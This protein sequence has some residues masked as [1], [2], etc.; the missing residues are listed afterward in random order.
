VAAGTS[1]GGVTAKRWGRV[2]D[3]PLIGAGTYASNKACAVSCTGAGEYFIRLSVAR[4]ICALVEL[5]G[6]SLQAACDQVVQQDLT[7][8]GGE[9]GV[10]AVGPGGETAW[11]FNT[12]GMY[13]ARIAE[14]E[15]MVVGIYKDDP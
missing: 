4:T 1:T 13:R 10:I 7:A 15:A 11:S 8:L 14:G 5:K 12:S 3:S 6:L 9:G 2:G